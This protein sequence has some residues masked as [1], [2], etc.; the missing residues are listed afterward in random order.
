M[1]KIIDLFEDSCSERYFKVFGKTKR[2]DSSTG[3]CFQ[4]NVDWSLL[5]NLLLQIHVKK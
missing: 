4:V 1:G 2:A 5:Q 3:K